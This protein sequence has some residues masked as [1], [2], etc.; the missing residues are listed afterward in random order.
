[1]C[2][3]A[4]VTI[5]VVN[6]Q[7]FVLRFLSCFLPQD[8]YQGGFMGLWNCLNS[9]TGLGARLTSSYAS[10]CPGLL[11]NM[12]LLLGAYV[13]TS[14]CLFAGPVKANVHTTWGIAAF[15]AELA[16]AGLPAIC[17]VAMWFWGPDICSF[18]PLGCRFIWHSFSGVFGCLPRFS[19]A[20]CH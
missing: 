18:L 15:W 13:G 3:S 11:E 5:T 16:G 9:F 4:F 19:G 2:F 12:F 8:S 10:F 1:M 14:S 17:Q 20:A 6:P 7:S